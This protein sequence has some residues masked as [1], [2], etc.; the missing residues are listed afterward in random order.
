M[1]ISILVIYKCIFELSSGNRV[2]AWAVP[3]KDSPSTNCAA[4]RPNVWG[5]LCHPTLRWT[6]LAVGPI[7]GVGLGVGA[8]EW[9][10]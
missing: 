3:M 9:S 6:G 1:A 7:A 10:L 8:G 2:G 4:G 5:R